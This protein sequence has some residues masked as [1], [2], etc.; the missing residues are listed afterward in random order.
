MRSEAYMGLHRLAKQFEGGVSAVRRGHLWS[1]WSPRQVKK[2]SGF[3]GLFRPFQ[4]LERR[5]KTEEQGTQGSVAV[6]RCAAVL[7]TAASGSGV[8]RDHHAQ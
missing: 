8:T 5:A 6:V 4:L 2:D 7:P 3:L 1:M